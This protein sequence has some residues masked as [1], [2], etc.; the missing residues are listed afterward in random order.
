MRILL[1]VALLV[2]GTGVP[3]YASDAGA[4][5]VVIGGGTPFGFYFGLSGALCEAFNNSGVEGPRC[6]NFAAGGSSRNLKELDEG[7]LDFAV[8]Q[9]DWLRH[10]AEGTS[11]YR[12]AGPNDAYRT[13]V[14]L[15]AE[16]LTILA[17]RDIGAKVLTHL[18]GRRVG[19]DPVNPY[20]YNLMQN[21]V[22]AA[23]IDIDAVLRGGDNGSA[24]SQVC[25]GEVDVFVTVERHPST[26]V[27][28]MISRCDLELVALDNTTI[29][30]AIGERPELI[31]HS[32]ESGRG[33]AKKRRIS[34][35]GLAAVLVT[36]S[37]TSAS[38]VT[39]LLE[40]VFNSVGETGSAKLPLSGI[41]AD[42]VSDAARI[43]PLH[44]QAAVFFK[45]RGWHN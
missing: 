23:R 33:S 16:S 1:S 37:D 34:T 32:I 7:S 29:E 31:A 5:P 15:P 26:R 9:S 17:R 12:A 18:A 35:L 25:T 30:K 28:D 36:S 21:A 39:R 38:V 24:A 27:A 45:R 43:A 42:D 44:E 14:S 4:K 6:L 11:R 20:A 13:I 2:F 3:A 41:T 8:V 22:D 19:F 10:A 40:A